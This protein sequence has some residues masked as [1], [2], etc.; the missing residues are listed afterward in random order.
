MYREMIWGTGVQNLVGRTSIGF[1]KFGKD[2]RETG[3]E[4][5]KRAN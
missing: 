3:I 5:D 4:N 2:K 1:R